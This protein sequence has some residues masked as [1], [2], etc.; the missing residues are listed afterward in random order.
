MSGATPFIN[1]HQSDS[2]EENWYSRWT[3]DVSHGPSAFGLGIPYYQEDGEL[4]IR[5]AHPTA[6]WY[7]REPK[8]FVAASSHR[9]TFYA[10]VAR[11]KVSPACC[12][13]LG[14]YQQGGQGFAILSWEH[15]HAGVIFVHPDLRESLGLDCATSFETCSG[16]HCL[17]YPQPVRLQDLCDYP[18]PA[19][20]EFICL[21][22]RR[23]S[24]RHSEYSEQATADE[25]WPPTHDDVLQNAVDSDVKPRPALY[26]KQHP[27][28]QSADGFDHRR[29]NKNMPFC[30]YNVMMIRRR[31]DGLASRIA[32]GI[33]HVEAFWEAEPKWE[34]LSLV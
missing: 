22:R 8:S 6:H 11:L 3:R 29:Y 31:A 9:L 14:G 30:L 23:G 1:H 28:M 16:G 17:S 26:P 7:E 4:S 15:F 21:S 25:I 32:I 2:Q 19:A 18:P 10:M 34:L 27:P 13:H 20:Y 5:F 33:I 12:L 24:S